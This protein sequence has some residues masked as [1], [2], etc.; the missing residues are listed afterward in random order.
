VE[1]PQPQRQIVAME[2]GSRVGALRALRAVLVLCIEWTAL[3]RWIGMPVYLGKRPSFMGYGD[4][5][6]RA[7]LRPWGGSKGLFARLLLVLANWN[8]PV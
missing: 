3:C 7:G 8:S 5:Y 4:G 6:P 2:V 1:D